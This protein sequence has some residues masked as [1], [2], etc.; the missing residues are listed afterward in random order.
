MAKLWIQGKSNKR[1]ILQL[2]NNKAHGSD[3]IP[4][5]AFKILQK[6][7][8]RPICT[9]MN[10]VKNGKMPQQWVEG[11]TGHIYK[12]RGGIDQCSPYRPIFLTLIIYKIWSQLLEKKLAKILHII[13]GKTQYG[14]KSQISPIDEIVKNRRKL[15]PTRAKHRNATHG[16]NVRIW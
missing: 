15:R 10:A 11:A 5:E 12:N 13:T 4:A 14:C 2:K 6:H 1:T 9:K 7:I 3:G 16:P 8:T